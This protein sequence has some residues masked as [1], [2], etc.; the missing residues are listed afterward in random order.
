MSILKREIGDLEHYKIN[1]YKEKNTYKI[2]STL[3]GISSKLDTTEEEI[4]ECEGI[5][6]E[7]KPR[8]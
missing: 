6:V 3:N 2:K 4:S 7:M 5:E 1:M 8:D